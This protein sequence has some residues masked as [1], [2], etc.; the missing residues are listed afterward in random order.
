M[1]VSDTGSCNHPSPCGNEWKARPEM[2]DPSEELSGQRDKQQVC[3]QE[4]DSI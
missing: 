3:P 1:T 4:G 2:S